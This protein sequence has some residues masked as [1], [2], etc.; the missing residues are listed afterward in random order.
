MSIADEGKWK[1]VI[2]DRGNGRHLEGERPSPP[3]V[4]QSSVLGSPRSPYPGMDPHW[5]AEHLSGSEPKIFPGV[6]SRGQRSNSMRTGEDLTKP[7]TSS[8]Y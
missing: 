6:V 3:P 8:E 7:P 4:A 5:P 2:V 1:E